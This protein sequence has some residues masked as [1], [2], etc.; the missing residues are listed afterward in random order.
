[1]LYVHDT[2]EL[3]AAH[4]DDLR[5]I[6]REVVRQSLPPRTATRVER[7]AREQFREVTDTV[8]AAARIPQDRILS[9][10]RVRAA[11]AYGLE[12]I[13]GTGDS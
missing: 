6:W 1:M 12:A 7:L 4:L 10:E 11:C 2:L 5:E 3:F 8:R 9:P 13:F